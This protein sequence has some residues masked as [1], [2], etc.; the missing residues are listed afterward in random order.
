[1]TA[2]TGRD[3]RFDVDPDEFDPLVESLQQWGD[4]GIGVATTA[5]ATFRL[6]EVETAEAPESA[7]SWRVEFLL[8]SMA[9][10]SRRLGR[11]TEV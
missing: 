9:D 1:L 5:R 6:T 10:P 4:V 8:Q 11:M 2:L 7:D 3:G